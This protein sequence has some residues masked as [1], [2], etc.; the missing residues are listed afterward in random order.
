MAGLV[1]RC[2]HCFKPLRADS[3]Q[4]CPVLLAGLQGGEPPTAAPLRGSRPH[5]HRPHRR[6][7]QRAG[8]ALSV[9]STALC[10]WPPSPPGLHLLQPSVQASLLPGPATTGAVTRSRHRPAR[11]DASYPPL[12]SVDQR[13]RHRGTG[14]GAQDKPEHEGVFKVPGRTPPPGAPADPGRLGGRVSAVEPREPGPGRRHRPG[15]RACPPLTCRTCLATPRI[16]VRHGP[17]KPT[18]LTCLLR[19]TGHV[20][21][22][23][24]GVHAN[25]QRWVCAIAGSTTTRSRRGGR[26]RGRTRCTKFR[27]QEPWAD[28]TLRRGR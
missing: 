22:L 4:R 2:A 17:I 15:R 13:R 26:C 25:A 21:V 14:G 28:L 24:V 20:S 18:C 10:P 19:T 5:R 11:S 8:G 7:R 23:P 3:P 6:G 27:L 1:R 9:V 16:S 12:R